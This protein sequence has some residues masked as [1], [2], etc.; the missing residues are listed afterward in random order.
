MFELLKGAPRV[1]PREEISGVYLLRRGFE[2][3]SRRYRGPKNKPW[4]MVGKVLL[5][6]SPKGALTKTAWG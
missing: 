6:G 4:L 2:N 3:R 1:I 5:I